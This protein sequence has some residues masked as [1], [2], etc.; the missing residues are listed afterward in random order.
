MKKSLSGLSIFLLK[1]I[2]R[3]PFWFLFLLA[4][5][6][7]VILFYL[8]RYRRKVTQTNLANAFPEKTPL[9]RAQIEKKY[10]R[11]LA[12]MILESLKMASLSAE[13]VRKRCVFINRQEVE[14]HFER[15]K[16]VLMVSGHYANWEWANLSLAIGFKEKLLV[17][18]KPLTDQ[19]FGQYLNDMRSRFGAIMVPM[20]HTLR[21]IV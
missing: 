11:F 14:R 6:L 21:K 3:L 1:L 19:G 18:F 9:E 13:E 20:K 8:V 15:G 7:F 10:Y 4:D 16:S 17:I 12:D 2:A 5:L